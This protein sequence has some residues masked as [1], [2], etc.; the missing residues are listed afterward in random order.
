MNKGQSTIIG[1]IMLA[2]TLIA[3]IILYPT[4][5]T[6]IQDNIGTMD[7]STAGIVQFIPIF[8]PIM[9]LI[10]GLWYVFPHRQVVGYG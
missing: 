6:I 7:V 5:N 9:I 8:I 2:V 10:G 4:L 3:Y 1:M